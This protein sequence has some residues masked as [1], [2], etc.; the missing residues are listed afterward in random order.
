MKEKKNQ[1]FKFKRILKLAPRGAQYS[2]RQRV[3]YPM[4]LGPRESVCVGVCIYACI[5]RIIYYSL[6]I[7]I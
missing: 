5:A 7:P 6:Y 3:S 4:Q 1:K 2:E